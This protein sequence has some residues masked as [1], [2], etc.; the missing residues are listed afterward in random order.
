[1]RKPK[2]ATTAWKE[3]LQ[4]WY[5]TQ[6]HIKLTAEALCTS[7]QFAL[8]C[9]PKRL[10]NESRLV[11]IMDNV[12]KQS[13]AEGG[14]RTTTFQLETTVRLT[15]TTSQQK[16]PFDLDFLIWFILEYPYK[17]DHLQFCVLIILAFAASA[18]LKAYKRSKKKHRRRIQSLKMFNSAKAACMLLDF[19]ENFGITLPWPWNNFMI[20]IFSTEISPLK[21]AAIT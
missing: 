19:L 12:H 18:Y 3:Q 4:A 8:L 5:A 11:S 10:K 21:R 9:S 13:R 1:M 14:S 17:L 16:S 20:D 2:G 6:L 7:Q 15:T